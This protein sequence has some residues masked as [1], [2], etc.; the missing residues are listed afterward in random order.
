M[1]QLNEELEKAWY[2]KFDKSPLYEYSE[3]FYQK[4]IRDDYYINC[5]V[6]N[7]PDWYEVYTFDAQ[8]TY[9]YKSINIET[10]NW[11]WDPTEKYRPYP[12]LQEVEEMF[13]KMYNAYI[14]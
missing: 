12:T 10:V 2:K 3:H 13:D 14:N 11:H 4:K 7:H 6:Y 9:N 1:K 5:I 8:F